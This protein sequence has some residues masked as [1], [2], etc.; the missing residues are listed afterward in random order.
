MS[1][2]LPEIVAATRR[3]VEETRRTADVRA[4]ERAATE[5]KP[6]G[7]RR[8]LAEV[9][10]PGPAVIAELKKASPSKGLIRAEWR[11]GDN[12]R[13]RKYYSLTAKGK[14]AAQSYE[15]QWAHLT[16]AVKAVLESR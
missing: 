13:E 16:G 5:H 7:F 11:T 1:A 8:R 4:L 2:H 9:G 15:R 10:A 6:R 3:R 14:K 12:G